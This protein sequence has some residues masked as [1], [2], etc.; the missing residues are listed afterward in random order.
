MKKFILFLCLLASISFAQ[1]TGIF[2]GLGGG[3]HGLVGVEETFLDD[4]LSVNAHWLGYDSDYDFMGGIGVAYRFNGFTGPYVFHSSEWLTGRTNDHIYHENLGGPKEERFH[5]WRLV[6][7]FGLQHMFT[8]N[9]G[10]FLEAG[11][12]FYAG[13]GGYYTH[14]DMDDG[15]LSKDEICLP[16]SIGMTVQF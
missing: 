15:G 14:L 4:H 5:Y 10:V 7:G 6:F 8:K 13:D 16:M 11:F 2:V 1:K 3:Y 9:L 12:E